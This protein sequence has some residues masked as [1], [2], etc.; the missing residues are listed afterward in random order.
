MQTITDDFLNVDKEEIKD[1]VQKLKNNK[2]ARLEILL[3]SPYT[4]EVIIP[5][6]KG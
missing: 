5:Y 3:R 1:I 4:H 2:Y 6:N